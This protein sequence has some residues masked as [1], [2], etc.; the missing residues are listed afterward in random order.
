MLLAMESICREG[1]QSCT[2]GQG[3]WGRSAV[4]PAGQRAVWGHIAPKSR[5]HSSF[6]NS[7]AVV[8]DHLAVATARCSV[9]TRRA[10]EVQRRLWDTG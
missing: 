7:M 3:L 6:I 9:A 1:E 4:G 2:E 5:T 10:R 8:I